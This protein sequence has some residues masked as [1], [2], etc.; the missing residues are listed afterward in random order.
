MISV[1][2][3]SWV[4]PGLHGLPPPGPSQPG[5]SAVSLGI[6]AGPDPPGSLRTESICF[7]VTASLPGWLNLC[8]R[9]S[10][11]PPRPGSRA[12]LLCSPFCSQ[13]IWVGGGHSPGK[14]PARHQEECGVEVG[15]RAPGQVP[16]LPNRLW[17][18]ESSLL[19]KM[20][21]WRVRKRQWEG[22]PQ[23]VAKSVLLL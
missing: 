11:C 10:S 3:C 19:Y 18:E 20:G 23:T 14:T 17:Q 7:W 8:S 21:G 13:P 12:W 2:S 9:P 16:N 4:G 22:Q 5:T 6:C 15:Q 1:T